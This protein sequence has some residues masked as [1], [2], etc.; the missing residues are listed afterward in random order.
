MNLNEPGPPPFVLAINTA[1]DDLGDDPEHLASKWRRLCTKKENVIECNNPDVGG[2]LHK[3]LGEWLW[4]N[5]DHQK[6]GR[7]SWRRLAVAVS[8]LH[9]LKNRK[10]L[11]RSKL[12]LKV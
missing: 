11:P 4:L 12:T 1:I 6:H 8:S 5:Y 10:K 9:Y 3:A 7:P 2:C